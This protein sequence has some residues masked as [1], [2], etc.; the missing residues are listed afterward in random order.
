MVNFF[1]SWCAPCV[2]EMPDLEEVFQDVKAEVDFLGFNV[3]D[4]REDAEQLLERTGVT[5]TIAVD[6]GSE[7]HLAFLGFAMPTTVLIDA[8]GNIA[9]SHIGAITGDTLREFI[10]EDFGVTV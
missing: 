3:D 7:I 5:Y 8:D 4:R 2:A 1:A 10:A 9:R 6:P